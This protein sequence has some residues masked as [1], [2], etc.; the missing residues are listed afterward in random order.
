VGDKD[1]LIEA[2][3]DHPQNKYSL[4]ELRNAIDNLAGIGEEDRARPLLSVKGGVV[5][6][7]ENFGI[8][9]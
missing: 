6:P 9:D 7:T 4:N 5:A 2:I 1:D 8:L 3:L